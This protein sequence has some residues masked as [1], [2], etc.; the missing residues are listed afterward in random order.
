M[1][2]NPSY[3]A[4]KLDSQVGELVSSES[5]SLFEAMS[6]LEAGNP[7][8]DAAASPAS[9]RPTLK[10]LLEDPSVA[11]WDLT[12]LELVDVLDQLLAME[13]SWHTGGSAMQTVYAC[14]YMLKLDKRKQL[15]TPAARA[16]FAYCATLRCD[17][18]A[19][20]DVA[21]Q[22]GVCEEEDMNIWTP[23]IPFEAP[24]G[25][26]EAAREALDA[27][28][29]AFTTVAAGAAAPQAANGAAGAGGAGGDGLAV[30]LR[31]RLRRAVH[32]GLAESASDDP[33]VVSGSA[34]RFAEARQ[35]LPLIRESSRLAAATAAATAASQPAPPLGP[36]F[37]VD[38]N[39][40]LLG[41][42]PPRQVQIMSVPDTL[43]YYERMLEHLVVAVSTPEHVHDYRSL[44]L[45]LWR[46]ARMRPGSVA[47]SVAH[48]LLLP[49]RWQGA[50]GRSK[51]MANYQP[52]Q[53]PQS[54]EEAAAAQP[55]TAAEAA[56]E[57][58]QRSTEAEPAQASGGGDAQAAGGRKGRKGK[59]G[60]GQAGEGGG[61]AGDA[62]TSQP[63]TSTPAWVP[64]KEMIA[65]ACMVA[66]K[67][68][69]PEEVHTFFDQA[70]IA[71]ANVALALLTNRCRC[72]R[73]LRR[74]LD[75]WLNMW[76][77][78]Y[79]ADVLPAFKDALKAGGWRW[80]PLEGQAP[81]EESGPLSTWVEFQTGAAM[82]HH[83]LLGFELELYEPLE[84]DMVY[85]YCDYICTSMVQAASAVLQRCPP[86][87]PPAQ[88]SAAAVAGLGG[89]RGLGGRGL[90]GRGRGAAAARGTE[91]AKAAAA[92]AMALYEKE[93]TQLRYEVLEVEAMQH[94]CQG[95][96]RMMAGLRLAGSVPTHREP[97]P[98]N[99]GEQRFEQRFAAFAP[100]P[101]PPPLTFGDYTT[102]MDLGDR[103][104][105]FLLALAGRSFKEARARCAN[106]A[107]FAP[108]PDVAAGWV[109]G[110]ERCAALN[111]VVSG[112][113]AARMSGEGQVKWDC[114]WS[115]HPYFPVITLPK[116][117][118]A[119]AATAPAAPATPA[120]SS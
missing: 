80:K 116:A 35:L 107:A 98:F 114:D 90:G 46:F 39:R 5:F 13:A 19:V 119:P 49:E 69:L 20:R 88:A 104:P 42:A 118:P 82:L 38:V 100:L 96:L 29:D 14:L 86:M 117:Q 41:P 6:A 15:D 45:Y 77:H 43:S 67:P 105:A 26:A 31:L 48:S 53:L 65:N 110:L 17:C 76:H 50:T 11:P 115:H 44:Q 89:G 101:R 109:R 78:G 81:D 10:S 112:V 94:M 9:D 95:M 8:M 108:S 70:V 7:K 83:L 106:L 33:K 40:H 23:G 74:C 57:A 32:L 51:L 52:P 73:R 27:A 22:G 12:P 37:P 4:W 30:A 34:A 60:K 47:R 111:A 120:A 54:R 62:S 93:Q 102:S 36:A 3:G 21:V 2:S 25:A 79:N 87:P 85:W 113:L 71:V 59:G 75:D 91:A 58:Q 55:S 24:A 84:Y 63:S 56:D 61:G 68:G 64:S 16:L 103:E 92:A 97:P 72:R 28:I 18:A 99:G 1:K 66:V